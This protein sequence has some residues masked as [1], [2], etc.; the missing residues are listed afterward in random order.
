M[1]RIILVRLFLMSNFK[2]KWGAKESSWIEEEEKYIFAQIKYNLYK[3]DDSND[4]DG[5]F[6]SQK[7]A[8]LSPIHVT[9]TY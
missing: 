1:C 8:L 7:R 9:L 3:H 2:C 4:K 6:A 5:V